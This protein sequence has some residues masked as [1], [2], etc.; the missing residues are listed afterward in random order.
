MDKEQVE[1]DRYGKKF[2]IAMGDI[3]YFKKINDSFGHDAGDFVLKKVADLIKTQ[4]RKVDPL[5]PWGGEEFLMVL[6]ETNLLGAARV[7]EKN[8]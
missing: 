6:P 2:A 8:Q 4:L 5:S 1:Y 3:D 7:T